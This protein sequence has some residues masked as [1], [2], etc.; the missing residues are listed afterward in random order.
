[1][2]SKGMRSMFPDIPVTYQ[3]ES[4]VHLFPMF[5]RQSVKLVET[6][7]NDNKKSNNNSSITEESFQS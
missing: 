5:H 7:C 4:E 1:M 6:K 3:V 2:N